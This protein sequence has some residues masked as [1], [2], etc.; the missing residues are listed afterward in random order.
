MSD[1]NKVIL[2]KFLFSIGIV[3]KMSLVQQSLEKS[4]SGTEFKQLTATLTPAQMQQNFGLADFPVFRSPA[5]HE[6]F[7]QSF[8]P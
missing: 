2:D 5:E 7:L 3:D 8:R 4:L 6:F 1:A